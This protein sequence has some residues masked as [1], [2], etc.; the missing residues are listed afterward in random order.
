[1]YA[2]PANSGKVCVFH[3]Y[4]DEGPQ[5]SEIGGRIL[6]L[7]DDSN[8]AD[9]ILPLTRLDRGSPSS[10]T[11]SN[12]IRTILAD[13]ITAGRIKPGAEIDE[14]ELAQRFGA[15]RTPVREALRELAASGLVI[16]EPR[17]GARVVEMTLETIGELFEVMAEVEAICVRLATYRMS[18]QERAV[19]SQ[20]H[21]EALPLVWTGD[22][23]GYDRLNLAFHAAIYD[24]THNRQLREHVTALRR[25]LSP[26]RRA[27]FRR[28]RR[29]S[30]SY[31]E[32]GRVLRSIFL[33]DGDAAAKLMRAHMLTA[34]TV[35][36]D[37]A[38]E[39]SGSAG[40]AE[41]F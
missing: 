26:F 5:G 24:A 33:G 25:R 36:S 19:L 32:H 4:F 12:Q 41:P 15:S 18:A 39:H 34:G 29:L 40:N 21:A 8:L 31:A 37:Y 13:D 28:A 38:H 3:H 6:K 22:V 27:Q 9:V 7:N 2:R 23:D 16:I 35:Y 17:K 30:A 14:Q 20:L 11:L 1:L 10:A